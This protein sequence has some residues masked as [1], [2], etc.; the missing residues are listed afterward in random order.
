MADPRAEPRATNRA[1]LGLGVAAGDANMAALGVGVAVGDA[2]MAALGLGLA[3][4]SVVTLARGEANQRTAPVC[5]QVEPDNPRRPV[6][7]R[8]APSSSSDNTST[9]RLHRH[10]SALARWQIT[11]FG[12]QITSFGL[13][14]AVSGDPHSAYESLDHR[15][16]PAASSVGATRGVFTSLFAHMGALWHERYM[17]TKNVI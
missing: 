12:H 13:A 4:E 5:E 16:E 17:T 2:N 3:R 6:L 9:R 10:P 8:S 1:A 7:R 15:A 14:K 11:S